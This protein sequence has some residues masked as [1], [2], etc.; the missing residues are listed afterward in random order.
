MSARSASASAVARTGNGPD[1]KRDLRLNGTYLVFRQLEQDVAAFDAF[2]SNLAECLCETKD[3]V[4]ARLMG[5]N[6]TES[7]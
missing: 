7:P 1:A 4:R 6:P 5:Q 2:V 3:W